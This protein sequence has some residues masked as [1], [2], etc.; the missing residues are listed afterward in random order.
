MSVHVLLNFYRVG[1]TLHARL[2]QAFYNV[3]WTYI[4]LQEHRC[5]NIFYYMT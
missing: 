2:G 3:I 5:L 1:E 4:I